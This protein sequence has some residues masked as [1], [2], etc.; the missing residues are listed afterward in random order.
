[1]YNIMRRTILKRLS[2]T[3][4]Y[5]HVF[6]EKLKLSQRRNFHMHKIVQAICTYTIYTISLK[7]LTHLVI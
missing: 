7:S 4:I 2:A 6:R 1:M 5:S 3:T